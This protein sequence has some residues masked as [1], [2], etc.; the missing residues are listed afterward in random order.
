MEVLASTLSLTLFFLASKD[1][2]NSA[3]M[4]VPELSEF[5]SPAGAAE[6]G[7]PELRGLGADVSAA[8]AWDEDCAHA[9]GAR[10]SITIT[11]KRALF[12]IHSLA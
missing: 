8:G 2:D 6:L 10:I 11:G 7:A 12:I 9:S 4:T 5:A 1:L 3:E